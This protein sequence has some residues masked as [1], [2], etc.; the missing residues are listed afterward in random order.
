MNFLRNIFSVGQISVVMN[1][2]KMGKQGRE[3]SGK[4]Y[5]KQWEKATRCRATGREIVERKTGVEVSRNWL[6]RKFHQVLIWNVNSTF[7]NLKKKKRKVGLEVIFITFGLHHQQ[8][9]P[10]PVSLL[11]L[12]VF[13]RNTKIL[14]FCPIRRSFNHSLNNC[15]NINII[16][17]IVFF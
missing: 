11:R 3:E 4:F 5:R 12:C 2:M 16:T 1:V 7:L 6:S 15:K 14:R 10:C 9:E 17:Q 8:S 13:Y